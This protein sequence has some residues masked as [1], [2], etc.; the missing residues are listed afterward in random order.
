VKVSIIIAVYDEAATVGKLLEQVWA[1]NVLGMAKEI[2]I[3]ESNSTDGSREIVARFVARCTQS[4]VVRVIYQEAPRGKGNAIREGLLAATGDIVVI[5]DADLEYDVAD[6]PELLRPIVEGRAAFV[7]GSR[8]M[9]SARWG[10]RRFSHENIHALF[11]NIGGMMFHAFFNLLYSTRLSDPTSMYKV[12][13]SDCLSGLT[14]TCDR[15]DFDFELLATLIRAGYPP[16]EIPVS[17]TSRGFHEGKKIRIFRDPLTWILAI[18][19]CRFGT[20]RYN[21]KPAHSASS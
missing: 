6:Y 12:F 14:F 9:G 5:Q 10:I 19:R 2:I 17:Y 13:R 15:F 1:Q 16:L 21:E 3:V 4:A 11:M 18:V 7:L 20:V 8:H